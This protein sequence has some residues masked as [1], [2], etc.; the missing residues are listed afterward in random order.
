MKMEILAATQAM[1][2][3]W[4]GWLFKRQISRIDELEKQIMDEQEIRQLINDKL[5]PMRVDMK[6][7]KEDIGEM[8]GDIKTLV[9]RDSR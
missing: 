3:A 1:V 9:S 6:N 4:G 2:V 7:I 8:K 5:C